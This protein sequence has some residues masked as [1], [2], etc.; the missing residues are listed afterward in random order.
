LSITEWLV[1]DEAETEAEAP[2]PVPTHHK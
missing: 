1:V 2:M